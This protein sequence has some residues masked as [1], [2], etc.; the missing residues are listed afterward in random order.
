VHFQR[1]QGPVADTSKA[2]A[3]LQATFAVRTYVKPSVP[4]DSAAAQAAAPRGGDD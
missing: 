4:G 3:L 2:A 1:V